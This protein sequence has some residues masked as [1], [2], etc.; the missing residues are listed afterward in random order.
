MTI[1]GTLA[2]F[3]V[4]EHKYQRLPKEIHLLGKQ[5]IQLTIEQVHAIFAAAEV[6][7][8]D[9]VVELDTTTRQSVGSTPLM[10]DTTFFRVFGV[11]TV[12]AI[13][14][15]DFEGADIVFDLTRPLPKQHSGCADF[16]FDGSVMDNV[17]DAATAMH[18]VIELLRPG[19]RYVGVNAVSPKWLPAYLA[20]N[21]Y[22]FFDFFVANGFRDVKVYV[23]DFQNY[24]PTASWADAVVHLLDPNS[25][26]RKVHHYPIS[27]GAV[28]LVVIAEKDDDSTSQER[29]SQGCYRLDQEW[30]IHDANVARILKSKRPTIELRRS[31][32]AVSSPSGF[33]YV[34]NMDGFGLSSRNPTDAFP[35]LER[36]YINLGEAFTG[37]DWGAAEAHAGSQW[38]WIDDSRDESGLLLHLAPNQAYTIEAKIHT[39]RDADS[40]NALEALCDGIPI[41][42]QSV[43]LDSGSNKLV[44]NL[45]LSAQ[46]ANNPIRLG[47]RVKTSGSNTQSSNRSVALS[48]LTFYPQGTAQS[49]PIPH[50][51][52]LPL[53][54]AVRDSN[55]KKME[56]I[57]GRVLLRE[58]ADR[59]VNR[60][61]RMF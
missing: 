43:C 21:P 10:D 48:T 37:Y 29:T 34:G 15:S 39:C 52:N 45:P 6:T 28:A 4:E 57:P 25:N 17:F 38:R 61:R 36:G 50:V 42:D 14:H 20:F 7:P 18:N 3:L 44:V 26:H 1:S 49:A 12:R 58:V 59:A 46:S 22:W 51:Q 30:K 47:F 55:K 33:T 32:E 27:E 53:A 8:R 56:T 35:V 19:G 13:D 2:R 54:L 40:M 41:A 23:L 16:I 9:V 31:T 5:T 11:D 60:L 24:S